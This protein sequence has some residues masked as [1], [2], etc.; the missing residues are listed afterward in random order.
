[1]GRLI[2]KGCRTVGVADFLTKY[3]EMMK[4][5]VS[6]RGVGL[7]AILTPDHAPSVNQD[8][9]WIKCEGT[10]GVLGVVGVEAC[11]DHVGNM[12]RLAA[13]ESPLLG[14]CT[15]RLGILLEHLWRIRSSV[16]RNRHEPYIGLA[17]ISFSKA[18]LD[19]DHGFVHGRTVVATCAVAEVVKDDVAAH[20]FRSQRYGVLIGQE[21]PRRQSNPRQ[22]LDRFKEDKRNSR[23]KNQSDR[24]NR[25]DYRSA[26]QSLPPSQEGNALDD[27]YTPDSHLYREGLM[28][29]RIQS[30][31]RST[32]PYGIGLTIAVVL[33]LLATS[34][35]FPE[36]S[37]DGSLEG[38]YYINGFDQRGVE[39][40][41]HL[42]ITTTD[43]ADTYKMQW[44]VT[45]SVQEGVGTVSG[46]QLVV[47][48][49]AIEGY[50]A[51]SQGTAIYEIGSDGELNG[52]RL[53][54]GEEG[55]GTEEALPI[56]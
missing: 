9:D 50:N 28:V 52:E 27:R 15:Q 17:N 26:A 56:R 1:M 20:V 23:K 6:I 39:Y 24:N 11:F 43:A 45:G 29:L 10:V 7:I 42:T 3:V 48:W 13:D 34:C 38:T 41:G 47:E 33:V 49:D 40:G 5:L 12:V 36:E 35:A 51:A 2:G 53:V 44:I 8:E 16:K 22:H 55:V 19:L 32:R 37:F 4:D 31:R 21:I 30:H 54:N 18:V 25:S 14:V 46:D